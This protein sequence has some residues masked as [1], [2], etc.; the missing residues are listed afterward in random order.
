M[1][2]Y[3]TITGKHQARSDATASIFRMVAN[4]MPLQINS[5]YRSDAEQEDIFFANYT[6]NYQA[7]S[8]L[9]KRTYKGVPYWR[10][11]PY[12]GYV[13]VAI[14]GS[15]QANHRSGLAVDFGYGAR[16]WLFS[17]GAYYGWTNPEWAKDAATLEPWHW[18]YNPSNDNSKSE[19]KESNMRYD[20]TQKGRALGKGRWTT[21]P[22]TDKGSPSVAFGACE[23]DAT[24]TIHFKAPD[25]TQVRGRF[26]K[27]DYKTGKRAYTYEVE[28]KSDSPMT[29]GS[30]MCWTTRFIA[31]LGKNERLR[32][33]VY[34]WDN[35]VSTTSSSY[36]TKEK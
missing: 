32:F 20:M 24:V 29:N 13:S 34:T 33:E 10:R 1:A 35:G 19:S 17:Y 31:D 3:T 30:T 14:P 23:A 2:T 15:P 6:S 7:S 36:R 16:N 8:K 26:Y 4:G 5:G 22:F 21:I 11:A 12:T 27:V 18:E 28:S 9:D 25:G